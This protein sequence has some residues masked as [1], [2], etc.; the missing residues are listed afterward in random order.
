MFHLAACCGCVQ[1]CF[2]HAHR[3]AAYPVSVPVR[4]SRDEKS[5][6]HSHTLR[7]NTC[8]YN[9][10]PGTCAVYSCMWRPRVVFLEHGGGALGIFKSPV[11]TLPGSIMGTSVRSTSY[12]HFSFLRKRSGRRRMPP[13]DRSALYPL[14]SS[15]ASSFCKHH[16]TLTSSDL[17]P[18]GIPVPGE[19][20]ALQES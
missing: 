18:K 11:F 12:F 5:Y 10:I 2:F 8:K 16:P 3:H 4:H 14:C 17:V 15:P 1:N 6:V 9:T 19:G 13:A 20:A 7:D